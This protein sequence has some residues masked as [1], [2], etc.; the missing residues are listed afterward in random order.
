MGNS[1]STTAIQA[2]ALLGARRQFFI[3][4]DWFDEYV[5]I[6][7]DQARDILNRLSQRENQGVNV[8]VIGDVVKIG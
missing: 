3:W 7:R 5:Q 2:L 6:S 8:Y 4:V 1:S